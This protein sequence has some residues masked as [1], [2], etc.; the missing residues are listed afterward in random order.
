MPDEQHSDV[1]IEPIYDGQHFDDVE[2]RYA[3]TIQFP[4]LHQ[5][6]NVSFTGSHN[7]V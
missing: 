5:E 2:E 7:T 3:T 6:L 1:S 4:N